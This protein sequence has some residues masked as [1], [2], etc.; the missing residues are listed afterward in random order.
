MVLNVNE[1][2]DRL[3]NLE[4]HSVFIEN[5]YKEYT[6]LLQ[7]GDQIYFFN[8]LKSLSC[9]DAKNNTFDQRRI[10]FPFDINFQTMVP[11]LWI[12]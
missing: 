4:N 5:K 2:I 1:P 6:Q 8:G 7:N 11:Y 3:Q 10:S 12:K 9:F